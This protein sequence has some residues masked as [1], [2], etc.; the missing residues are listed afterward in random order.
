LRLPAETLLILLFF[1]FTLMLVISIINMVAA[2]TGFNSPVLLE[3]YARSYYALTALITILLFLLLLSL[4]VHCLGKRCT[5]LVEK[6]IK[7]I[8]IHFRR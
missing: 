8:F 7:W 2:L 6:L 4:T 3:V 1:A 5:E